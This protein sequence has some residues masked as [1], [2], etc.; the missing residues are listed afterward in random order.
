MDTNCV[1]QR[2][3]KTHYGNTSLIIK[4]LQNGF[5]LRCG[6]KSGQ[7]VR[8]NISLS[9]SLIF[10]ILFAGPGHNVGS[11]D[12]HPDPAPTSE[13]V[14][15]DLKVQTERK[16]EAE[17]K[18]DE[19]LTDDREEEDARSSCISGEDSSDTGEPQTAFPNNVLPRK[20]ALNPKQKRGFVNTH[21][22]SEIKPSF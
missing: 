16:D 13:A 19:A 6:G 20:N 15:G 11:L 4:Y 22:H 5:S 8:L 17:D 10:T 7:V 2:Q 3:I 14:S 21:A 1:P 18:G 12:E 9:L